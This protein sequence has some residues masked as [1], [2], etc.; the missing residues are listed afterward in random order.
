LAVGRKQLAEGRKW[1]VHRRKKYNFRLRTSDFGLSSQF[2]SNMKKKIIFQICLVIILVLPV[3]SQNDNTGAQTAIPDKPH[4]SFRLFEDDKLLEISL[5]FDMT[6]YLRKK[7]SEDYLKA[8]MTLHLSK[9]DSINE[10]IRLRTR[11]V[12]R[13]QY[14]YFAPIELNFK[15]ADFGYSDLNRI[16]KIKLV[17]QCNMGSENENYIL[18][19]FLVYKLFNVLTDTSFRV[20]LLTINYI[21]TE[22][23]R[24]P[25][26]QYG[27]FIEPVEMLN[28]RTHSVQI[29]SRNLNQKSI[30]PKL[31]D[32]LAIFNYMVGNYDWAVPPLHNVKIIKPLVF[33]TAQLAIAIPYD[34]DWTGLVNADYA[35]PA[36]EITGTKSVRERIFLGVCRS[37]E[38]YLKD[39][40]QFLEK[41]EAFYRV[42]NEF[43][44]LSARSKKDMTLYLDGF[45]N[46]CVGRKDIIDILLNSCKKF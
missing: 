6:T 39:L 23:K 45:F 17:P 5:R 4:K 24:K 37:K 2:L 26:R 13:N 35:I 32:R 15:K 42:I 30:V 20:R 16:S 11:G 8:V 41:K 12:F 18:R 22:K 9:T 3:F 28:A 29:N 40:E 36:D 10:D 46:Q 38:V 7:P 14:C 25:I 43:P 1:Y 33:D 21:D 44:Y 34:F 31:M 27:F 19:E